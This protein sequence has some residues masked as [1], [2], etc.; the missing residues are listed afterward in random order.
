MVAYRAHDAAIGEDK[1]ESS[2]VD[3]ACARLL[4]ILAHVVMGAPHLSL[5]YA[6]FAYLPLLLS[7]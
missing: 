2:A 3:I 7:H 5:L 1:V 4:D 6:R